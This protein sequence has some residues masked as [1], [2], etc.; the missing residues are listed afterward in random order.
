MKP[1]RWGLLALIAVLLGSAAP[2]MA[3]TQQAAPPAPSSESPADAARRV[4]EQKKAQPKPARVWDNDNLPSAQGGVNVVGDASPA[5]RAAAAASVDQTAAPELSATDRDQVQSAIQEA[6]GKI[7]DLRQ[8]VSIAQR[9]Y[10]LDSEMYYGKPDYADDKAGKASL[11]SESAALKDKQ[12]QLKQA[13]QILDSM[14]AKLGSP[15]ETKSQ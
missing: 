6:K 7:A 12:E 14:Q 9:K 10:T 13:E 5:A 2:S 1:M 15:G 8:D 11:D 3:Q 4:R